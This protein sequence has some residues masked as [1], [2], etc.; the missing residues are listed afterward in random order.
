MTTPTQLPSLIDEGFTSADFEVF[1]LNGLEQRMNGIQSRIQPK[2]RAIGERLTDV[3]SQRLGQEM[4]LHIAKHARRTVNAPKDTWLSICGNKRGYKSHPHF[5]LGLFD[6]HLFIWLAL[7][8]ELPN[9]KTIASAYL[10]QIDEVMAQV[11][12]GYKLSMDHMKKDA[13]QIGDMDEEAW[14]TTLVRFR[15]V[16]K[17]ELLIG[18]HIAADDP[19]LADGDQLLAYA[20]STYD[21]LLPLYKMACAHSE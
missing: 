12:N 14:K 5:Q 6:D 3:L 19:L 13:L 21:A 18:R 15:D 16:Q 9:K 8:Y 4:F 2:F 17:A 7:I 11:P 1:Q 20:L 10:T